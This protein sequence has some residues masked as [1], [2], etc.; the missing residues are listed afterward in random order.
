MKFRNERAYANP[1]AAARKLLEIANSIEPAQDGRIFI[2][3]IN[4]PFLHE[5]KA[6]PAEYK[7]GLESYGAEDP[8]VFHAYFNDFDEHHIRARLTA[9]TP[10][11]EL[12]TSSWRAR[13]VVNAVAATS[14]S[15]TL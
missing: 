3:P 2:E 13:C 5:F 12:A 6:S 14:C 10:A 1:E 8:S 4:W 15:T 11:T 7:A 9:T